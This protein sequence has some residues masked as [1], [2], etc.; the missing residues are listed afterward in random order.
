[1]KKITFTFICILLLVLE[2]GL[3]FCQDY[4]Y[5]VTAIYEADEQ[6]KILQQEPYRGWIILFKNGTY[7]LQLHIYDEGVYQ[8]VKGNPQQPNDT[9]YFNSNK[10]FRYF[11]YPRQNAL[12]VWLNKTNTGANRWA[13]AEL[14][15]ES[16]NSASTPPPANTPGTGSVF[17]GGNK[18]INIGS[19]I[20]NGVFSKKVL[21][22]NSN[23]NIYHLYDQ[24]TGDITTDEKGLILRPNGTYFLRS[25][26]G[27]SVFEEK[28]NYRILGD[29]VRII[30]QDNSSM[31]LTIEDGGK[32]LYWYDQGMLISEYYFLGIIE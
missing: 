28:G 32:A 14:S 22:G 12:E 21:Y 18:N 8:Y 20:K 30:F 24:T 29:K 1:M 26:L 27:N 25:E 13:H 5:Q 23:A 3:L 11:A 19:L 9:L 15:D 16:T 4:K 6:G 10:N 2:A 31:T 17:P 7:K